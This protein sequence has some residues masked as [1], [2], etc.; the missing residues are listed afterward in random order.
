MQKKLLTELIKS[1]LSKKK[2]VDELIDEFIKTQ[3]G[4]AKDQLEDFLSSLFVYINK[5]YDDLSQE[6]LLS[7]VGSKLTDLNISFDTKEL[8]D[9]Y[10][11]IS[12]INSPSTKFEFDKTDLAAIESM[13]KNFYWV[14]TE[15]SQNTQDKV[16]GVIE[17]AFKGK[18]TREEISS[19]LKEQFDTILKADERYFEG[20]ADH[21]INQSQNISRVNQALKYNV[22]HFQVKA[23]IDNKT[24]DICRS[25]N[26]KIIESSH[27]E[28][29][30][31]N[32]LAAKNIS[33]KKEAAQW[34]SEPHFGKLPSNF[35]L[36]PYHFRCRTE[37]VPVW[38][39]ED[40][41]EGKKVKYASKKK[42]DII[43]HIDKTGVQRRVDFASINHSSSSSKRNVPKKD[44]IS[45]L[46]S[47]IEISPHKVYGNRTVAKSSNGYF[48]VFDADY[49]Y[50]IFK[51]PR[52]N[53]FK[54]NA[55]LDKKEIIKWKNT[56]SQSETGLL[57]KL[58]TIFQQSNK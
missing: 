33:E 47:I 30:V 34:K 45:A 3:S 23:R 40:E 52:K 55:N 28:S 48:M 9:I 26:G 14:G 15:Y 42:D 22:K 24:S 37:I 5:N 7:I 6:V 38:L 17:D 31:T 50:T 8:D 57:S 41:I 1:N 53:Y 32:V 25:L 29:Q 20:V 56:Q 36:P 12:I 10:K 18:T 43:T 58:I 16:K 54:D 13:R 21:I 4:F 46:N 35:G 44:I 11:R 51:E 2:T 39:S 49:L 27:L 19:I